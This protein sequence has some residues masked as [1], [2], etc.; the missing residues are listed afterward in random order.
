M[1]DMY[2]DT[3]LSKKIEN[4]VIDYYNQCTLDYKLVW[5]LNSEMCLHY[6]YWDTST[7][8]LRAAIRNMNIKL[9]EF[10]N[11]TANKKILDAGCGAGGSSIFLAKQF[12]ADVT[13]IAL[14][15]N[16]IAQCK[17]NAEKYGLSHLL[18]FDVQNYCCTTL[19]SQSFDFVWAIE[20]VCHAENK[21]HFL[22]EAFRLLKPGGT[23]LMADFFKNDN[24]SS[25]LQKMEKSWS[26]P[27]FASIDY[28]KSEME[29]IG[30]TDIKIEDKSNAVYPSVTRL[31]ACYFPGILISKTME[32]LG[33]RT[34]RQ[35]ENTRSCLYQYKAFKNGDWNYSF[36][37]AQ[38]PDA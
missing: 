22:Q 21:A 16:Q 31:Y 17:L 11:I 6:G 18:R 1:K 25:W 37:C 3:I 19:P 12:N 7:P 24:P 35:T 29:I 20:S 5:H 28:F 23:L 36:I 8:N 26:I 15:E 27:S 14:P 30:F 2:K 38:K 10:G 34:K 9:A 32:W 4:E 33:L 13:G